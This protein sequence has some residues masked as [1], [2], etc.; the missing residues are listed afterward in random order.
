MPALPAEIMQAPVD[1]WAQMAGAPPPGPLSPEWQKK[2]YG[3]PAPAPKRSPYE[4]PPALV[5]EGGITKGIADAAV[6][7]QRRH[8][9]GEIAPQFMWR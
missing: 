5:P 6:E 1:P 2:L 7:A 4:P 3:E 9:A 8:D